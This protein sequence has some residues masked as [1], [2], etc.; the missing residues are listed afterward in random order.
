MRFFSFD[1]PGVKY[2]VA[3]N[4]SFYP[5]DG[6]SAA[7]PVAAAIVSL[8]N[9]E[10]IKAGKPTVGWLNPTLYSS[11]L[12]GLTKDVTFGAN[13]CLKVGEKCCMQGFKASKGWDPVTG[14]GTIDF[15]KFK[16][17]F[18]KIKIKPLKRKEII[19]GTWIHWFLGLNFF[20][21][22]LVF[23]SLT[24]FCCVGCYFRTKKIPDPSKRDS[25]IFIASHYDEIQWWF[26]V[27]FVLR[28]DMLLHQPERAI[29][30]FSN[31]LI[32]ILS[33]Y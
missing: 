3:I 6:T 11:S 15:Y 21:I 25:Y 20:Y 31:M 23:F 4:G 27:L 16:R 8:I 26:Y 29:S 7:C 5:V 12:E 22:Q 13:K 33:Y 30:F 10:R 24:I 9:S 28:N 1:F 32:Q 19:S 17:F 14:W 2:I 18:L